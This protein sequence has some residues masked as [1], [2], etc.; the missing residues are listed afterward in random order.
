MKECSIPTLRQ[1]NH[2]EI[3]EIVEI[4]DKGYC[5]VDIEVEGSGGHIKV[6]VEVGPVPSL[7]VVPD[8]QSRIPKYAVPIVSSKGRILVHLRDV[9]IQRAGEVP[10]VQQNLVER[11]LLEVVGVVEGVDEAGVDQ[12]HYEE[13]L[14]QNLLGALPL[15]LDTD[16]C[17]AGDGGLGRHG[18]HSGVEGEGVV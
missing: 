11:L 17:G 2:L 10:R 13:H 16:L 15:G 3:K 5:K 6:E 8:V 14:H 12:H 1:A 7:G 18:D 4:A 9:Q